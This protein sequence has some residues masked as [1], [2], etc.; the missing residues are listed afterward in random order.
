MSDLSAAS[1][2]GAERAPAYRT[3]ATRVTFRWM[4]D[5]P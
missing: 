5:I 3:A 4:V 2:P 1:D